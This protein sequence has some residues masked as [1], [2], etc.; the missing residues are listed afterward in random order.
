RCLKAPL[1]S[2]QKRGAHEVRWARIAGRFLIMQILGGAMSL[3]NRIIFAMGIASVVAAGIFGAK[4]CAQT[5]P[6]LAPNPY[7]TVENWAKLPNGRTWGQVINVE[8][9][10]DGKS[11]W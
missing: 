2:V 5:D 10:R 4:A 1:L 9:D 7:R 8:I 6:N 11:I 3:R